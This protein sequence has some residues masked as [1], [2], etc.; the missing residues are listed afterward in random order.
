MARVDEMWGKGEIKG[1]EGRR[2]RR[3]EKCGK[4]R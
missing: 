1:E 4:M 2:G 3:R